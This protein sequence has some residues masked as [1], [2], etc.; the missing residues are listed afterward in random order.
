[1]AWE[2]WDGDDPGRLQQVVVTCC[3]L[4]VGQKP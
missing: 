2:A 1:M 3:K 4:Q